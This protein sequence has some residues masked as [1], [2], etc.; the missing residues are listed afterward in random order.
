MEKQF[1]EEIKRKRPTLKG[2]LPIMKKYGLHPKQ[3]RTRRIFLDNNLVIYLK[4]D[5]TM[6]NIEKESAKKIAIAYKE[7]RT[8]F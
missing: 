2:V 7:I 8:H 4:K 1:V 3:K 6:R 5:K